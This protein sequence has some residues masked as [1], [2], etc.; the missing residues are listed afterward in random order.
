[1]TE[2]GDTDLH[3]WLTRSVGRCIGL[4]FRMAMDEGRLSP[5]DYRNLVHACQGCGKV[6]S[7]QHWLSGQQG[8]VASTR[9]PEFCPNAEALDSL[10]PH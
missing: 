9:A 3:F 5:E 4:N 7:C 6:T 1:M 8:R 2:P 10:K